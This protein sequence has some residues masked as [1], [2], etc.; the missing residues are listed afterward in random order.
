MSEE[1]SQWLSILKKQRFARK[2]SAQR[3]THSTGENIMGDPSS[4]DFKGADSSTMVV[5][6]GNT[7]EIKSESLTHKMQKAL[8]L[9]NKSEL[10]SDAL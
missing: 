7:T 5:S 3:L 2:S 4:S 9:R 10:V 1:Q 8:H 6:G